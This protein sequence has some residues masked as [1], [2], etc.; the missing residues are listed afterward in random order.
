MHGVTRSSSSPNRDDTLS[1]R[2]RRRTAG[3]VLFIPASC[4]LP[5]DDDIVSMPAELLS[6]SCRHVLTRSCLNSIVTFDFGVNSLLDEARNK[7]FFPF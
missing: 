2:S 4:V 1:A 7:A 6:I 3:L 5:L